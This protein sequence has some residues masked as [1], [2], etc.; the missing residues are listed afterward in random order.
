M[1]TLK[2]LRE[3]IDDHGTSLYR[4]S[5]ACGVSYST[6]KNAETRNSQLSVDTIERICDA[7]GMP[8]YEYFMADEDWAEIESY[9]ITRGR[10]HERRESLR[11]G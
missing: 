4:L 9:S 6:L 2:R 8:L 3:L 5:Q 7:L 1:D 10:K 11:A